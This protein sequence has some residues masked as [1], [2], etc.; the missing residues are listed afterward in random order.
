MSA[1]NTIYIGSGRSGLIEE[2]CSEKDSLDWCEGEVLEY[3]L[4]DPSE[5]SKLDLT[6]EYHADCSILINAL[7]DEQSKIERIRAEI[8]VLHCHLF[9]VDKRK[10]IEIIDRI[11]SD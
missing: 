9:A 10:V 6:G 3:R 2:W 4:V 1:P 5:K 7:T 8:E 11:Q